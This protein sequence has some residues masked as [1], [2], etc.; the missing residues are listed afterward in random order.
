VGK[1]PELKEFGGREFVSFSVAVNETVKGEKITKWFDVRSDNKKLMDLIEKGS[2]LYVRGRRSEKVGNNGKTY[3]TVYANSFSDVIP[4]TYK[5]RE[6]DADTDGA[7][8][9]DGPPF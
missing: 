2:L 3:V 8:R 5:K 7:N 9:D 1:D 4:Y 6:N